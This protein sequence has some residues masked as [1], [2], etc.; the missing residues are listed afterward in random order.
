M[1]VF[2]RADAPDFDAEFDALLSRKRESAPDVDAAVAGIVADVRARGDAAL[3]DYTARFDRLTL[4]PE[5]L[6]IPESE[7][8][9]AEAAAPPAEREALA[10]AAERDPRLSRPPA[11]RGCALDRRGGRRDG[12][13]LDAGRR[14]GALCARRH[15]VLPVFRADERHPRR[16]RRREAA[17][18]VRADARWR[19]QPAGAGRGAAGRRQRDL[20]HRRRAGDRGAGLRHRDHRAGRRH[21]R[22][23][24][25]L[26]RRRQ[27]A[28]LRAGRH[29]QHRRPLRGS[30]HRRQAPI[31]TGSR[32]T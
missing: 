24:Q 10:L 22:P 14:G 25:R 6:A 32:S 11:P 12:L 9:A 21:R 26:C 4:T 31:P 23:R 29:R 16:H 15:G 28:G 7:I 20:P 13:A 18:D 2:L 5:T 17:G 1:P 30:G 3:I 27:A 19:G 8:D